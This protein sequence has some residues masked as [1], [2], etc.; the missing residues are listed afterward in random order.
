MVEKR[1][2]FQTGQPVSTRRK[3]KK[4]RVAAAQA[5]RNAS[6]PSKKAQRQAARPPKSVKPVRTYT[7]DSDE[8]QEQEQDEEDQDEEEDEEEEGVRTSSSSSHTR[9]QQDSDD[10]DQD[11]D[12]DE[13]SEDEVVGKGKKGYRKKVKKPSGKKG[14]V[15]ADTVSLGTIE[16]DL[17]SWTTLDQLDGCCFQQGARRLLLGQCN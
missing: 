6:T 2:A 1:K 5:E 12:E 9:G 3:A 11:S 15:F 16:G 4:A 14:K 17:T 8:D 13:D 10:E 7:S